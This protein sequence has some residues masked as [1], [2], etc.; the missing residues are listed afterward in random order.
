MGSDQQG[1][2]FRN[3]FG[4]DIFYHKYAFTPQQQWWEKAH[5]LVEDV[6]GSMWGRRT[7]LMSKEEQLMLIKFIKEMKFIPAGRYVY[8]AKRVNHSWNNCAAL[9]AQEDTREE[10]AS[11]MGRITNILMN[12]AGLSIEYSIFR[13]RGRVLGRTGGIASGPTALMNMANEAGR[14]IMQGGSRRAAL[15]ALLHWKHG[16]IQEFMTMKNWHD[17]P[18][19]NTGYTIAD[20]KAQDF[21]YPAPLDMTNIS[22]RYDDEFLDV[23]EKSKKHPAIF[24]QNVRQALQ[25]AEPGFSF[26]FGADKDN[27]GRNVCMEFTTDDDN[28]LCNLGSINFSR[29]SSIDELRTVTALASKF[30]VCGSIRA[31]LPFEGMKEVRE[32]TRKIGLGIMG[33]HEWLMTR[34][35]KYEVTEEL[36]SWL[37]VYQDVSKRSADTHCDRF[38]LSRPSAYRAIAPTGSIGILAGTTGGIEPLYATAYKRRYLVGKDEWKHQYVVDNTAQMLVE[39]HGLD[40]NEIE[41]A[42][43]LSSDVERRIKFQADVQD[44]V[45]MAISSTVNLP[46]WGTENNNE[47]K[48]NEYADL[49]RKYAPRLRGL[50]FYPDGSRG[51]QPLT[52]CDFNEAK[53]KVG[54]VYTEHDVCDI[55]HGGSCGD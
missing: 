41:T 16:D 6:C 17:M 48:V 23:W 28:D 30:L 35:Y 46:A 26:N 55:A 40:P 38:Y 44:Y 52:V 5:D 39:K 14:W 31:D 18:V 22:V 11:I 15:G 49:I 12:G 4:K 34:G 27:I 7:P 8:Y 2:E 9:I 43:S 10:W 45:D 54:N 25:T 13:E 47:S 21:D 53:E 32:R 1:S 51:G 50:T 19:G 29:I 24:I 20:L 3:A 33:V 36:H 42:L 37:K